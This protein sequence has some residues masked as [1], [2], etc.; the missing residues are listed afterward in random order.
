MGGSNRLPFCIEMVYASNATAGDGSRNRALVLS[1]AAL[2]SGLA[3][4]N[5]APDHPTTRSVHD[6]ACVGAVE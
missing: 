3:R 2:G 4:A 6:E 1:E 5:N